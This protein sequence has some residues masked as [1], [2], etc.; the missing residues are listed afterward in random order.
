[1]VRG[2]V[3]YAVF[4]ITGHRNCVGAKR[5]VVARAEGDMR[6]SREMGEKNDAPSADCV[7]RRGGIAI[8]AL[9][10]IGISALCFTTD[11]PQ[12]G[13]F[14]RPWLTHEVSRYCYFIKSAFT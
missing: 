6:K 5:R 12:H 13:G 4:S 8:D 10:G 1:M 7:T 2:Q 9:C 3:T 14:L 11:N